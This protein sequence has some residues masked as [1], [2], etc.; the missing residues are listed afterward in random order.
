M[1]QTVPLLKITSL[2]AFY[3][4]QMWFH[5]FRIHIVTKHLLENSVFGTCTVNIDN[6]GSFDTYSFLLQYIEVVENQQDKDHLLIGL[7]LAQDKN[8]IFMVCIY[9]YLIS[10][11]Y[12]YCIE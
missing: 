2:R 12:F 5:N 1:Q 7:I 8:N 3:I 10:K 9:Q 11:G 4:G 6:R